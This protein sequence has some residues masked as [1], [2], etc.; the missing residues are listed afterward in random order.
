MI[1]KHKRK[2]NLESGIGKSLFLIIV[3]VCFG[4]FFISLC[5]VANAEEKEA[6]SY[7]LKEIVVL[8]DCSQSME[9]VDASYAAF[10]FARSLSAI[11][12]RE[13]RVGVVAYRDEVCVSQPLG[14]SHEMIES[15]LTEV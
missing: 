9:D 4:F 13:Y 11:L 7:S 5:I 15:A 12:P 6:E 3:L 2:L 8:L 10:D 14:S 1:V